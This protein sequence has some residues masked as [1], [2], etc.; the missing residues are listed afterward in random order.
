VRR[1]KAREREDN[2]MLARC[3]DTQ[4]IYRLPQGMYQQ[5]MWGRFW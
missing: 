3:A 1:E 2:E 4:K 5:S